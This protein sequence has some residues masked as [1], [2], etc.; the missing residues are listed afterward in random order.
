MT[1]GTH[2]STYGGNPLGCA[3]GAKVLEIVGDEA[4]LDGVRAKAG[5]L[6]QALEGLVAAHPDVFEAV[7]GAG[8]MLGLKCKAPVLDVVQAG[9]R[10][11][12]LTVPAAENV[13]RILPP[14][15]ISDGEIKEA[16]RRLDAA[17]AMLAPALS[18][19]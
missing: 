19:G 2:G 13:A 8:L 10:A 5:T 6:R 17:A 1:A 11:Q 15:T 12:V 18:E 7:R 16:V 9:Y 4:F 14:L 3:V